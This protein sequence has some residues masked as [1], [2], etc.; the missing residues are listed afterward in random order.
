M[1]APDRKKMKIAMGRAAFRSLFYGSGGDIDD[2]AA[3][4]AIDTIGD[5]P[6]NIQHLMIRA[7]AAEMLRHCP[8]EFREIGE[9]I[10]DA[11]EALDDGERPIILAPRTRGTINGSPKHGEEEKIAIAEGLAKATAFAMGVLA[12]NDCRVSSDAALAMVIGFKRDGSEEYSGL[13]KPVINPAGR[14]WTTLERL[15]QLGRKV[16]EKS[17]LR[18]WEKAGRGT[19]S[20][21]VIHDELKTLRSKYADKRKAEGAFAVA[22]VAKRDNLSRKR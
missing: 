2:P 11:L 14:S 19:P 9:I 20:N 13:M 1:K 16:L 12:K 10:A 5:Q 4:K 15:M 21:S 3:E 6:T 7:A 8:P 22:N 18:R 17:E